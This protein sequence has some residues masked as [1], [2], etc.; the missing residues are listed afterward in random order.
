MSASP[1]PPPAVIGSG[2]PHTV[3]VKPGTNAATSQKARKPDDDAALDLTA[4]LKA[5]LRR[6][7]EASQARRGTREPEAPKPAPIAPGADETGAGAQASGLSSAIRQ[8]IA[9]LR[10]RNE[11]VGQELNSLPPAGRRAR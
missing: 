3:S 2:K 4:R 6:G 8:R 10:E 11:V 7:E 9:Q 1:P 5:T